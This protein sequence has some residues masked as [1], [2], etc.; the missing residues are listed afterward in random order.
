MRRFTH[1]TS[2]TPARENKGFCGIEP[3]KHQAEPIYPL[4]GF[5]GFPDRQQSRGR[6]AREDFPGGLEFQHHK[7]HIAI[8][9]TPKNGAGVS[10]KMAAARSCRQADCQ[11][12]AG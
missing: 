2:S 7:P 6:L 8:A 4:I 1:G 3:G 10:P 11:S 5:R 12:A 9:G